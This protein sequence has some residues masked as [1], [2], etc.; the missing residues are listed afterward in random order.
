MKGLVFKEFINMVE[1]KFGYETVDEIIEDSQLASKGAYT[2]VGTYNH[3]EIITLVQSLSKKTKIPVPDLVKEFGRSLMPVFAKGF[4]DFFKEP[5]SFKFLG[6]L[7][8]YIHVEVKKLYPD[9]ELPTF[10]TKSQSE[11]EMVL[12]YHSK[13]PLA[14]LAEGLIE[15]LVKH[16]KEDIEISTE[17]PPGPPRSRTFT[18]KLK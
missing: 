3:E 17:S 18:L 16:Y 2:S 10:V 1:E 6:S 15:A 14:D 9:A 12:E 11:K 4:P 5:N 13:R 7:N 8:D